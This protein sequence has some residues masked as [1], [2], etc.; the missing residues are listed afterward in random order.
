MR[1]NLNNN[2]RRTI[3]LN[4]AKSYDHAIEGA[5]EEYRKISDTVYLEILGTNKEFLDRA[6]EGFFVTLDGLNFGIEDS[7]V[8]T[9]NGDTNSYCSPKLMFTKSFRVPANLAN[10]YDNLTLKSKEISKTLFAEAKKLANNLSTLV[11]SKHNLRREIVTNL[12]GFRTFKQ[13][14]EHW[15]ESKNFLEHV[16][17]GENGATN[18]VARRFE[19]IDKEITS[20][21][22]TV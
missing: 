1:K 22:K 5:F 17:M 15:P 7:P 18:A 12:E 2:I 11:E 10:R 20:V 14:F 16:D 8:P 4:A 19:D 13:M 9:V 6:P 21:Q 3:A